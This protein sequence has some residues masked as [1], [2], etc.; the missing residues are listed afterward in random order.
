MKSARIQ[1][2]LAQSDIVAAVNEELRNT[3]LLP[4]FHASG[5]EGR[6]EEASSLP[7]KIV[8]ASGPSQLALVLLLSFAATLPSFAATNPVPPGSGFLYTNIVVD[9]KPWSIHV[10]EVDIARHEY[11][12]CTTLGK[13]NVIGMGVV[14]DQVK[15]VPKSIG[16]PLAAIN[17]DFYEKSEKEDGRPRDLQIR[18]GEVVSSPA[19]HDCFWIAPDDT[20]RMTN[21]FSR[22]RV[23]WENG[24]TTPIGLNQI[25]ADDDAV[26]Y[27]SVYGA[28]TRTSGGVE[29][30]L[31][32]GTNHSWLPLKV[33]CEYAGR[34]REVHKDGNT[35]L[36]PD[37]LVLSLGP[38]LASKL[39]AAQIGATVHVTT[40]T[41]PDLSGVDMAIGGGPALLENGKP[42]Q[43]KGVF[44][45]RHPRTAVGWNKDKIFMVE[46]DGRQANLSVGMSFP[47]LADFMAQLGCEGA[48]NF[49]GGG[50]ATLW[51][52]GMVKNSPSEGDERPAPNALVLVKKP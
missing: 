23:I 51:A 28:T 1:F 37:I 40:E 4:L 17:G 34:I 2:A 48:M 52:F 49:D 6:G 22:F 45:F 47:E 41:V 24:A 30:V 25:R 8:V 10:V 44:K 29:L 42:M 12:F 32:Q 13:G 36:S 11:G 19:G 43:W 14:S 3:G 27:T 21:V 20:P 5:G 26:L 46:V 38:S 18:F 35:P 50:S 9:D 16:R 31:E 33:G 7:E 39:P 15:S